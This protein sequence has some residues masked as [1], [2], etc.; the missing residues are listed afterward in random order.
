MVREIL[1]RLR[2]P[3]IKQARKLRKILKRIEK[4]LIYKIIPYYYSEEE[5]LEYSKV[6]YYKLLDILREG[7]I[8]NEYIGMYLDVPSKLLNKK[9]YY[10][11]SIIGILETLLNKSYSLEYAIEERYLRGEESWVN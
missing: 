1:V 10:L 8:D 3:D 2:T 9:Y 4:G 11:Y 5:I 6:T 7:D